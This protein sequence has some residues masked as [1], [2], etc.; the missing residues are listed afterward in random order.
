M[1]VIDGKKVF[2]TND[3]KKGIQI[4]GNEKLYIGSFGENFVSN[5]VVEAP[6]RFACEILRLN[7]LGLFHTFV[8]ARI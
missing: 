8:R 2:L 7:I 1:I 3:K 4:K 6:A 5:M